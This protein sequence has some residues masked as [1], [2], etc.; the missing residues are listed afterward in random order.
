[1]NI[2]RYID[3]V[4]QVSCRIYDVVL[5]YFLSNGKKIIN[6]RYIPFVEKEKL[7]V[8]FILSFATEWDCFSK[9]F[10]IISNLDYVNA[11]V[12]SDDYPRNKHTVFDFLRHEGVNPIRISEYAVRKER[13]HVIFL[14]DEIT[15]KRNLWIFTSFARVVYIPYGSSI[16]DAKYSKQQQYNLPIHN[17]AWRVFVAGDFARKLYKKY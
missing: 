3:Y 12:I 11:S 13:P 4:R 6:N 7:R 1:M 8:I 14:A 10:K 16:S 15:T 5:L 9:I 17:I 2:K